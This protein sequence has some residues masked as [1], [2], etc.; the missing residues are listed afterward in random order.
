MCEKMQITINEAQAMTRKKDRIHIRHTTQK[1]HV[2]NEIS[3]I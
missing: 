2:K 1:V 3:N